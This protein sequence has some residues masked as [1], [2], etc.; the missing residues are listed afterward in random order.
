MEAPRPS[1]KTLPSPLP[2]PSPE[3]RPLPEPMH[4]KV[5][6]VFFLGVFEKSLNFDQIFLV[7]LTFF[8]IR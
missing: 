6:V 5:R 4:E 8:K 2:E 7:E 3:N 1:L